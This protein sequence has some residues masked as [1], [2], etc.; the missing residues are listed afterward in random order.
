MASPLSSLTMT[1]GGV[2]GILVPNLVEAF[3]SIMRRLNNPRIQRHEQSFEQRSL[4]WSHGLRVAMLNANAPFAHALSDAGIRVPKIISVRGRSEKLSTAVMGS[5]LLMEELK[6]WA[7]DSDASISLHPYAWTRE[8][9]ALLEFLNVETGFRV[10]PGMAVPRESFEKICLKSHHRKV[11]AAAGVPIPEASV[12]RD[13][14]ELQCALQV[15]LKRAGSVAVK[16]DDG[17]NGF[18]LWK[19]SHSSFDQAPFLQE[20]G[21]IFSRGVALV[22]EDWVANVLFSPSVEFLISPNQEP[23][24]LRTAYQVLRSDTV[25]VGGTLPRLGEM[26]EEPMILR[27]AKQAAC[28][29]HDSGIWGRVGFDLVVSDSSGVMVVD[30]NPRLTGLSHLHDFGEVVMGSEYRRTCAIESRQFNLSDTLNPD[31]IWAKLQADGSGFN[32]FSGVLPI[33]AIPPPRPAVEIIA[34][35]ETTDET[36]N[37]ILRGVSA[38]CD[39]S[40]TKG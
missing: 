34:I 23:R 8:A 6:R 38:I 31:L 11:L 7:A 39:C 26:P 21:R 27:I 37:L 3:S 35:G 29:I 17:E 28:A 14:S 15:G 13:I 32:G 18:G 24:H 12:A 22:V 25:F 9:T 2:L 33:V 19:V 30:V 20:M 5:Q 4:L 1:R 10:V 40:T 36:R 16:A